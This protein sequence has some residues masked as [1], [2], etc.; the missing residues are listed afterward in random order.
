MITKRYPTP[1]KNYDNVLI[2]VTKFLQERFSYCLSQGIDKKNIIIDPGFGCG[3]TLEHNYTLLKNLFI[4]YLNLL[5]IKFLDTRRAF[6][7]V[8]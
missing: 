7:L 4:H 3:K 6:C 2:D 5:M 8:G 1:Y